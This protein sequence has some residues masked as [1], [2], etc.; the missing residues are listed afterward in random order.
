MGLFFFRSQGVVVAL[1]LGGCG[2]ETQEA[3]NQPVPV[4]AT[5]EAPRAE[6]SGGGES[7]DFHLTPATYREGDRVVLPVVFTEGTRA[8]LVYAPKLDI[9][10]LGVG[11]YSSGRLQGESP[12]PGRSDVVGRDFWIFFGNLDDV[13][14][15]LNGGKP[16]LLLG[17]NEGVNGQT[18]G[19][20]DLGSDPGAD[21][22][23]FQF[24]RWAVLVY[25]YAADG[26]LPGAAMTDA[27]RASWATSFSGHETSEGFLLL[28]GAGSLLRLA[29]AG[30]HAGP[31][32]SF[33]SV[34][35]SRSLTL[36]PGRCSPHR[37]QT[38]LVHGKLVEW[39]RGSADWCLS[40][41]MRIQA[42]GRDRFIDGLIR[43]LAVRNVALANR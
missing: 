22:L 30:E 40:D 18:V 10:A 41:S 8:E 11:P 38:R 25:D 4:T 15:S 34:E 37:D 35:P 31:Q 27:E 33:G 6:T 17:Q 36:Y 21:Y 13:L 2:G 42:S 7:S 39:G 29:R 32:L 19:F 23:G 9:A 28:E 43:D 24:G 12:R 20:W 5:A 14:V 1:L 3:T 26:H 16:P